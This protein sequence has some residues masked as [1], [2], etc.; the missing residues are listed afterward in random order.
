[1]KKLGF[2]A[3]V[4]A[5]GLAV[6]GGPA[7]AKDEKSWAPRSS[8]VRILHAIP[9]GPKVDVFVDSTKIL[10]DVVFDSSVSKYIR[11]PAGYHRVRIVANN[12]SHTLYNVSTHL[13][14]NRFYTVAAV[15]NALRPR[16]RLID[17]TRATTN[18]R[19]ARIS[20][21]HFSAGTPAIDIGARTVSGRYVKIVSS[22][23]DRQTRTI[24]LTPGKYE[25]FVR[26]NGRVI[27]R[28]DDA[29]PQAGRRY[30]GY[31]V[32]NPGSSG[33][34]AFNLIFDVAASQ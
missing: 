1:M 18:P 33:I 23:N 16:V 3:V 27:K 9:N 24:W 2:L 13:R 32:G 12:P 5:M 22:L 6:F 11:V 20:I 28:I 7:Q 15:G 17:E 30:A 31:A 4:L 26:A 19:Q 21:T 14:I 34:N 10:N 25:Q 8:Y 29:E